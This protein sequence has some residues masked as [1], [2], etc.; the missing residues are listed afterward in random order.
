VTLQIHA[1]FSER[2]RGRLRGHGKSDPRDA[3]AIAA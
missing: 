1:R 3:H 2:E